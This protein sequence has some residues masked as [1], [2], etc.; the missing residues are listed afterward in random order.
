[1][2]VSEAKALAER[3]DTGAMM[4]LA[5]YYSKEEGDEASDMAWHYYELAANAGE[6]DAIVKMAQTSS[7]MAATVFSMIEGGNR[8]ASMDADIEKAYHWAKK[9]DESVRRLNVRDSDTLEFVNDNLILALSRVVTLYY[10]DE[11]YDDMI[12]ATKDTN[13]PYAQAMYGLALFKSDADAEVKRAFDLLKNIENDLCWK[14]EFQT[15]FGQILLIEAASYLSAMYRIFDHD[16]NSAYR[17]KACIVS[18][19]IDESIRR[20]VRED[21]AS[22]FKKS[23]FGGYIYIGK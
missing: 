22:N 16:A 4:A 3:G 9:L 15:K 20:D 21:M 11:R 13:H 14:K 2:T 17:V 1:M 7:M 10:L 12:R 8:F 18:H 19:S 6:A 5:E 23:L